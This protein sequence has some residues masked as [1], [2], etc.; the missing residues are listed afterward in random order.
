MLLSRFVGP[1]FDEL[2]AKP[3]LAMWLSQ[4]CSV[5]LMTWWLSPW[6][7]KPFRRWL[8]P[9]WGRGW[10]VGLAGAVAV[11]VCYAV[12]LAVFANVKFLQFWD[13]TD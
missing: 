11:V 10:R 3:W 13:F 6:A 1:V 9:V 5:T 12:T 4:V 7:A 8:D 2:G